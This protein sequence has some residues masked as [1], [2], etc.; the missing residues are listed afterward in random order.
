[1]V[2]LDV[3]SCVLVMFGSLPLAIRLSNV[4]LRETGRE[5]TIDGGGPA[6]DVDDRDLSGCL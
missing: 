5:E 2:V 3:L 4:L 1:M 6:T